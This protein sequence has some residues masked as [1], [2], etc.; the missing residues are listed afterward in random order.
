MGTQISLNLSDKLFE[1]AKEYAESKGYDSL[2]DLTREALREKIFGNN[3][4]IGGIYTAKA[5]EQSLAKRWLT[6]E[7]DDAWK[8]LQKET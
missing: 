1:L 4:T 8:H 5:S 6:K 2:Q 7:E 3:E